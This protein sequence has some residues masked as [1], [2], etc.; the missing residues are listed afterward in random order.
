MGA[1]V[2]LTLRESAHDVI[3]RLE[4]TGD[5]GTVSRIDDALE[6]LRA[7]PTSAV[8]RRHALTTQD[9]PVWAMPVNGTPYTIFWRH[10][11]LDTEVT[12]FAIL[13]W[14]PGR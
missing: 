10:E 2:N 4:D 7:D 1:P 13:P 12:V 14:S 9:G 3:D 5:L 8:A 11:T 6:T